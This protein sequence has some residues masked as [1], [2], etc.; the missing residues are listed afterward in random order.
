MNVAE[1]NARL[2]SVQVDMVLALR[3]KNGT[4]ELYDAACMKGD[5]A[6]AAKLRAAL[7]DLYDTELDQSASIMQLTRKLMETG[8]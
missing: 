8:P 7:H 1:I 2:R 4:K 6:E 3:M 5:G